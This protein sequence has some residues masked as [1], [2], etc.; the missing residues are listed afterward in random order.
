MLLIP[1]AAVTALETRI[2]TLETKM[3]NVIDFTFDRLCT[4]LEYVSTGSNQFIC[5]ANKDVG[6]LYCAEGTGQ[7]TIFDIDNAST[8]QGICDETGLGTAGKTWICTAWLLQRVFILE[9]LWEIN[10]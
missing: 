8:G 9:N 6:K 2:T 7:A 5:C 10:F 4:V 3:T 1:T